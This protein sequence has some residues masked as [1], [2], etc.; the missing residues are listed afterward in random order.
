MSTIATG[1]RHTPQPPARTFRP[2]TT[3]HMHYITH[4]Y[5]QREKKSARK[6]R[7]SNKQATSRAPVATCS[8]ERW[9]AE[10]A[11]VGAGVARAA[12]LTLFLKVALRGYNKSL[13]TILAQRNVPLLTP[14]SSVASMRRDWSTILRSAVRSLRLAEPSLAV[15]HVPR[16]HHQPPQPTTRAKSSPSSPPPAAARRLQHTHAHTHTRTHAHTHARALLVLRRR[17]NI[18]GTAKCVCSEL[19]PPTSSWKWPVPRGCL[20]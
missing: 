5:P 9:T 19:F 2:N 15:A 7:K 17:M 20:P 4:V 16:T 3:T 12:G 1:P 14:A 6:H 10:R 11:G 8:G 18:N 13:N